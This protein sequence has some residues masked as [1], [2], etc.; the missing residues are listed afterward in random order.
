VSTVSLLFLYG[1][2]ITQLILR[3]NIDAHFEVMSDWGLEIFAVAVFGQVFGVVY[4]IA[5]SVWSNDE[6]N[7][8]KR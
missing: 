3:A 5:Q 1:V 8:M 6:F 4:I 2:V 7:L